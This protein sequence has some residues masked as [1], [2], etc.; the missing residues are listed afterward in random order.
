[1][2][3]RMMWGL[4]TLAVFSGMLAQAES[5]CPFRDG[6]RRCIPRRA[7]C[8]MRTV[9]ARP[10]GG[11]RNQARRS[12]MS[13]NARTCASAVAQLVA[14]RTTEWEASYGPQKEKRASAASRSMNPLS[15]I[16]NC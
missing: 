13:K 9:Q 6:Q 14:R 8:C 11:K 15:R 4:L 12:Q 5:L 7:G 1:M 2:I 16:T 10:F 3:K